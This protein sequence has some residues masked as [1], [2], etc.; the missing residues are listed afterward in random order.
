MISVFMRRRYRPRRHS[1]VAKRARKDRLAQRVPPGSSLGRFAFHDRCEHRIVAFRQRMV[2]ARL[3]GLVRRRRCGL[4]P[5]LTVGVTMILSR[6]RHRTGR[7][8]S[9]L[10]GRW[11]LL[12]GISSREKRHLGS[13][14]TVTISRSLGFLLQQQN[15]PQ[16]PNLQARTSAECGDL[17]DPQCRFVGQFL[18]HH[19]NDGFFEIR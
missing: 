11:R 16:S 1:T 6:S 15:H 19:V 7:R 14:S 10:A 3:N 5:R 9:G 18:M 2:N 12:L 8:R 4:T 13:T 17:I